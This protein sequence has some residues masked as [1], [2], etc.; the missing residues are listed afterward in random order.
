MMIEISLEYWNKLATQTI[1]ISSLMSGFSIAVVV[2]LLVNELTKP[3]LVKIQ[4]AAIIAASSFLIALFSWTS[5][6]MMTTEGFPGDF[7]DQEFLFTRIIGAAAF[8]IGIIALSGVIGLSGWVRS[9]KFGIFTTIIS[10]ITLFSIF[11]MMF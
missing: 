4:G 2:S 3:I 1:L 6:L 5:I 7:S 9:K 10:I 8:T 11:S